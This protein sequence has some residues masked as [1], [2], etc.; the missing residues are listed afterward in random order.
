MAIANPV[1]LEALFDQLATMDGK[2]EIIDGELV[3]MAATGPWPGYAGDMVFVSLHQYAK[4]TKTGVTVSD[5]KIFRVNLP[6][7]KS[8]SPDAAYHV[9]TSRPMKHYD[10]APVFAVEV[11]SSGGYGPSAERERANKRADY[12]A[13]GTLVVW[14]VDLLSRDVVKVYRADAPE[15]PT[16]FRQGEVAHAEPAVPCWSMPVDDLLP[17][18][19]TH[20]LA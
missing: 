2:A 9:G 5:N 6:R 7:R 19:W 1:D 16:I 3:P 14:D 11:R 12:F 8:F 20:P 4:R 13:A 17:E 15:S 18:G 10:G